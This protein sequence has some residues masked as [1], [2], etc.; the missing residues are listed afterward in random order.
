MIPIAFDE[1]KK[2]FEV[3]RVDASFDGVIGIGRGGIVPA[4]MAACKLDCPL[5]ILSSQYRDD[6]NQPVHEKPELDF[7]FEVPAGIQ[8]VLIVDDVSVSGSTLAAVE[9]QFACL[10]TQTLVL[11]GKADYVL[12]PEIQDCVLW[13]WKRAEG[14]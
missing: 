3:L 7:D 14:M 12:F 10:K 11:K 5:W 13:P 4:L 6:A 8:S 2:R 9:K 1:I